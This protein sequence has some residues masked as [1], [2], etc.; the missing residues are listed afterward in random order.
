MATR[1]GDGLAVGLDKVEAQRAAGQV[2]IEPPLH[3]GIERSLG[4]AEEKALNVTATE[5]AA[6]ELPDP[7]HNN[8]RCW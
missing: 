1:G 3:F 6:E 5:A 7:I 8:S 4:V 2:V